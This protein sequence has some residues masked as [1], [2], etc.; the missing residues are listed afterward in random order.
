MYYYQIFKH[1]CEYIS[2]LVGN[3]NINRTLIRH[4][5]DHKGRHNS[6]GGG[7]ADYKQTDGKDNTYCYRANIQ[8]EICFIVTLSYDRGHRAIRMVTSLI[9]HLFTVMITHPEMMLML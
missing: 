2:K 1:F 9:D 5:Y 7:Y 6:G 8:T 4:G 3:A